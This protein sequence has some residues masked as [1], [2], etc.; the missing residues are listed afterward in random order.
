MLAAEDGGEDVAGRD[1]G[2]QDHEPPQAKKPRLAHVDLPHAGS[3]ASQV[4]VI[5]DE[6]ERADTDPRLSQDVAAV[7]DATDIYQLKTLAWIGVEQKC[8]GPLAC[9]AV[10][11]E[12]GLS[13]TLNNHVHFFNAACAEHNTTVTLDCT[14]E[15][16]TFSRKAPFAVV[17][18]S[19]GI[20]HFVHVPSSVVVFS[21]EL[22]TGAVEDDG[23][24]K[25][26]WVGFSANHLGSKEELLVVLK[27][28]TLFRF[29]N[30]DLRAL[31]LALA[32]GENSSA[33]D[34]Y[35]AIVIETVDLS[36]NGTEMT[37]VRDLA[38]IYDGGG[39]DRLIVVGEGEQP[40]TVWQK[41]RVT[42]QTIKV[43]AVVRLLKGCHVV[44]MDVDAAHKHLLLLDSTGRLSVWDL[45]RLFILHQFHDTRIADFAIA[46]SNVN[47]GTSIVALSD[48]STS[49]PGR[50]LLIIQLSDFVVT[51]RVTVSTHTWI[52]KSLADTGDAIHFV[53]GISDQG[54]E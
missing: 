16:T 30:I 39:R 45:N 7:N 31:E 44:K 41:S 9:S 1:D 15:H 26:K 29:T 54:S 32:A 46:Q 23:C 43:D 21:R 49:S 20:I 2:A 38:S 33:A 17:A 22:L 28:L 48:I 52:I 35:R 4:H 13:V 50:C 12:N 8:G 40:L 27:N 51:H 6:R 11:S 42:Q 24:P 34:I 47:G 53:E 19:S 5:L 3:H 18:D 37:D 25:F 14:V 36:N 10:K